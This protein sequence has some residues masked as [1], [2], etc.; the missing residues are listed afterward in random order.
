MATR[1]EVV[2]A[3]GLSVS[4]YVGDSELADLQKQAARGEI[5]SV[6]EVEAKPAT[7][8]RPGRTA[9]KAESVTEVEA[10]KAEATE[11]ESEA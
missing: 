7:K 9:K 4:L 8:A 1:V 10:D 5:K 6:T 2:N 11:A 3:L